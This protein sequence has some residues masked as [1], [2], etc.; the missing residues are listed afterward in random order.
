M[1]GE[2]LMAD[3]TIGGGTESERGA[4]A[5]RA[6]D[7]PGVGSG[8]A[9]IPPTD[10]EVLERYLGPLPDDEA[11]HRVGRETGQPDNSINE[12]DGRRMSRRKLE[13][14]HHYEYINNPQ[15]GYEI[16]VPWPNS[17]E[18]QEKHVKEI[19]GR[20]EISK[21]SITEQMKVDYQQALSVL[22]VLEIKNSGKNPV[23]KEDLKHDQ[24]K[25]QQAWAKKMRL[26]MRVR[27]DLHNAFFAYENGGSVK[28][29]AEAISKIPSAWMDVI[30]ELKEDI[31][32]TKESFNPFV[33][34]LQYYEDH[35]HEFARHNVATGRVEFG[36]KVM[37]DL[38]RR[39]GGN[40]KNYEWA[41]NMAERLFRS[42]GRAIMYDY[43]VINKGG[44]DKYGN[45]AEER[46]ENIYYKPLKNE[47]VEWAGGR[48]GCDYPM[49]KILR[50][51]ENLATSSEGN[52]M[53]PHIELLDGVDIYSSDYWRIISDK[54]IKNGISPVKT[55]K[56]TQEALDKKITA[57]TVKREELV[58]KGEITREQADK[59]IRKI[60]DGY[61]VVRA[62]DLTS[63]SD[64][65]ER[66]R[67]KE[68]FDA[69]I[70]SDRESADNEGEKVEKIDFRQ[71]ARKRNDK[72]ELVSGIDF[73]ETMGDSPWGIWTVRRLAGPEE[74]KK[75]LTGDPSCFLLNPNF[76]SLGKLIN[77]F[78]YSKDNAWKVKEQ[79]LRNFIKYA[80]SEKI[81]RTG[82]E[83]YTEEEILAGVNKLTG[84]TENNGV[85]F[86][87]L[88]ER[89]N[90]LKTFFNIELSPKEEKEIE[91]KYSDSKKIEEEKSK[92]L[93]GMINRKI[94]RKYGK[95]FLLWFL[96]G[97]LKGSW[98]TLLGELGI[99]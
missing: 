57:E 18:D 75:A 84:L 25:E 51:R 7:T 20:I 58:R 54:N 30:F 45:K 52:L 27:L 79:L 59:E 5:P 98:K 63:I 99:K 36:K 10:R 37:A 29:V 32:G 61:F 68:Y 38:E 74:A 91:G 69:D 73:E 31:P 15:L 96:W 22:E 86:V 3:G 28:E 88:P 19:L 48:D 95:T 80:R 8:R 14:N 11:L 1:P 97:V 26:E 87:Q 21:S 89:S 39:F 44:K 6:V 50:F 43:L 71:M 64:P 4:G 81:E 9:G 53:R 93:D 23:T 85:Q 92:K 2:R 12:E 60:R 47:S 65:N 83:K 24:I 66:I 41:Q 16:G 77:T 33:E 56:I 90:I 46:E 94:E 35:G 55:M 72:G 70:Y 78:D 40:A 42:T 82:K 49:S 13:P 17:R 76:E 62:P 34:A 67:Q